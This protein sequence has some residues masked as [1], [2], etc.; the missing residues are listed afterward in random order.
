[1]NM[2][3]CRFGYG[4]DVYVYPS[5]SG[6]CDIW[7]A[8]PYRENIEYDGNYNS[9]ENAY[10]ALLEL[11]L[12]GVTVPDRALIEMKEDMSQYKSPIYREGNGS[13]RS[14]SGI[15]ENGADRVVRGM[16]YGIGHGAGAGYEYFGWKSW[17][18]RKQP[19]PNG[20]GLKDNDMMLEYY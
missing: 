9:L 16:G 6:G 18:Y 13:G 8:S 12:R 1:M 4:S 3:Y 15:D 17:S 7:V 20:A 19:S 14:A 11:R 5:V 2:S 10:D